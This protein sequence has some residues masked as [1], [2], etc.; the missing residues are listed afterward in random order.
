MKLR[1]SEKP[2][3]IDKHTWV[4]LRT[5]KIEI[6]HEIRDKDENHFRTDHIKIQAHKIKTWFRKEI[7]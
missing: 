6:I 7:Q 4:Y 2:I 1:Y 3:T 5:N